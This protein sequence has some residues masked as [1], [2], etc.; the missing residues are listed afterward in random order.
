VKNSEIWLVEFSP[1][2]G[3]EIKKTRPAIVVSDGS[4]GGLAL[5]IVVPITDV[6]NPRPWHVPIRPTNTNHLTKE[7]V[8][9]CF[10]LKCFSSER[11]IKKTGI[12]SPTE[13]EAVKF[14]LAEVL[15]LP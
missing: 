7:C 10:Q 12:A 15:N 2:V 5:R 6:K 4:F 3:D 9:D 11:F 14:C 8:V 1:S 13:M